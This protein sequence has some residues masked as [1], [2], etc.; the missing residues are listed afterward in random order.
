MHHLLTNPNNSHAI[1]LTAV[2]GSLPAIAWAIGIAKAHTWAIASEGRAADAIRPLVGNVIVAEPTGVRLAFGGAGLCL[3]TT[4]ALPDIVAA[5]NALCTGGVIVIFS[6]EADRTVSQTLG[7]HKQ[8]IIRHLTGYFDRLYEVMD[9]NIII[10]AK[11]EC[12]SNAHS[13]W[14]FD[15]ELSR[16]IARYELPASPGFGRG[17]TKTRPTR[18][19]IEQA[20][21]ELRTA[22]P[23]ASHKDM[24]NSP[25]MPLSPGHLGMVLA[26]GMLDGL[27]TLAN[28]ETVVIKGIST[29]SQ[30]RVSEEITESDGGTRTRK[31][32]FSEKSELKIRT[33]NSDGILVEYASEPMESA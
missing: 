19:E 20:V 10:G 30:Y 16:A 9:K 18:D 15:C 21:D 32:V 12:F 1:D 6:V 7:G 23:K 2:G 28:G 5:T 17:F 24:P 27:I 25:L 33:I 14:R 13:S 29:K 22:K 26:S 11:R 8:Q 4:N 31:Q 3:V